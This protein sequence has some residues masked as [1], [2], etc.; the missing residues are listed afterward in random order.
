MAKSVCLSYLYWLIGGWFGL[1][2]IY[3]E[4]D[5]QAFLTWSLGAGYFGA[6]LIRD[7][8]RIPSYVR[9]ANNDHTFLEQLTKKMRKN[10]TV[11]LSS[12]RLQR[13]T[14]G[15]LIEFS[16]LFF[17]PA[18]VQLLSSGGAGGGG[19][20]MGIRFPAGHS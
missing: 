8:W 11:R 1:H 12:R 17:I 16:I 2:H 7:L 20:C 14:E 6:G 5:R 15:N 13:K 3:L 10:A 18:A 19:Q 4:R 9:D